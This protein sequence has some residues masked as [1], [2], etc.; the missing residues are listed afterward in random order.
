MKFGVWY[1]GVATFVEPGPAATLARAAE[2]A[3][4]DSLWA[5]EHVV[6]PAG[7]RSRYPYS[8][9]GK[10]PGGG[11][12]P[13]AEPLVWYAYVAG[14]TRTLRFATGV[15][16]VPQRSPLL[17]AKQVATLDR[18]SAGRFSLGVGAGWLREEFEALGAPFERRGERLEEYVRAM[19]AVWSEERASFEGEFVRFEQAQVTPRP[20]SGSVP[21]IV[22]GHGPAAARRAG[23]IGDGFF[24]A[25]G[26]PDEI[27]ALLEQARESALRAGRD[28]QAL[29][30]TVADP[31]LSG[32]DPL[33]VLERWRGAG[34]TRVLIPPPSFDPAAAAEGL[35]R[36]GEEVI[37]KEENR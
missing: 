32:P 15:L 23:R 24:P 27:A 2:T 5:G 8:A 28:P 30:L 31:E 37:S 35:A 20:A 1:A 19:R 3:G 16:V 25:K 14:L 18:L 36:L 13:M 4:F 29:E 12:V 21:I 33:T 17:L 7:H 11:A 9:D 10:L 34:A 26:S 22:G 6:I